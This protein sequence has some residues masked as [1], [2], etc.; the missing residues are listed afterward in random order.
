MDDA[1]SAPARSSGLAVAC[2]VGRQCGAPVPGGYLRSLKMPPTHIFLSACL[3][4]VIA[5]T[6]TGLL[7]LRGVHAEPLAGPSAA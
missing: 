6:A 4:A 1:R 7:A 2:I 5:A 3:F